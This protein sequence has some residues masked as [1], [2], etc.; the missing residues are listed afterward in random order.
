VD[1]DSLITTKEIKT[2]NK[3]GSLKLE[4]E[5]KEGVFITQKV[6][7]YINSNG[8]VKKRAKGFPNHVLENISFK[9]F[10][11]SVYSNDYSIFNVY[12]KQILGWKES[13]TRNLENDRL[14][15]HEKKVKQIR[16]IDT[17]RYFKK[18]NES[19][20]FNV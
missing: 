8:Q 11:N 12:W 9:E 2:D 13:L 20:P 14:L 4:D 3:L 7:S 1:T 5:I 10:K 18:I 6:Y 15:K 16:T 17:K 19:I